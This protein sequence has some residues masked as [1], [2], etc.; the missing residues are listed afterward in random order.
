MLRYE[1]RGAGE[2]ASLLE[3]LR[4][5]YAAVRE[6]KLALD[7]SR[8]KPGKDQLDLSTPLLT[9]VTEGADAVSE[10]GT[11]C[12]NY[13]P[14]DGIP[15]AKRL[16]AGILDVAPEQVFV[17]G[18][19]SLSLMHDCI[20][21]AYIHGLPGGKPWGGQTVK[22]LCPVP[23][24]DRHFAI[25]EH[26]GFQLIPVPM[27]EGGPD[28][29]V[30]EDLIRDSAVKGIWCV[31][32]YSNPQG[33]TYSDETVR[34]FAA[35]APAASDFRI[36]WDNAYAV[37]DLDT[38]T[39]DRLLSLMAELEVTG[40]QDMALLFTSTSKVTYA[41]GGIS[42]AAM[43]EANFKWF[44][45]HKFYQTIGYDKV[46]QLRHARMFPDKVSLTAHMA[47]HAA[48]L[49]PKFE[50]VLDAL[51]PLGKE[52]IASWNRPNGGYFISL[53]VL[54]GCAK[55][56][57]QLC[58][59]A[60]VVLT[61]AGATFPYGKDPEDQNIRIAPT[62]PPIAELEAAVSLLCLC[63]RIASLEKL[64]ERGTEAKE[65]LSARSI[66]S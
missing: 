27:T 3:E 39:P 5:E 20:T 41:G 22:F 28:M 55:R 30:V 47:R 50:A 19:A 4:K 36:F 38:A 52:G 18:N 49:R 31:P 8:G 34:R 17:G 6:R 45:G 26:F 53:D 37:H 65:T 25:T 10:N 32:K 16:F 59:E 9:T 7:M 57:V 21:F 29:D 23:G 42:A 61:G 63:V 43:S 60:G 24:Y 2:L 40:K 64:T 15:E 11:D 46:N 66:A 58:K 62:M 1:E 44:T 13:A 54:P 51:A 48:I 12:R 33:I 35:L 56:V 14:L